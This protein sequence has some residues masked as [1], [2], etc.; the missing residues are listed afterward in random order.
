MWTDA[1]E[2]DLVTNNPWHGQKTK[3]H[4]AKPKGIMTPAE[5]QKIL[6][7]L[8][9][10]FRLFIETLANTGLRWSEALRLV[11]DDVIGQTVHVRKSK[12]RRPRQVKISANLAD[13]LRASLP[14]RGK[15]GGKIDNG[16]FWSGV[17]Y[18]LCK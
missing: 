7:D 17:S 14:F 13:Q 16:T 18:R 11:P 9:P 4:E 5:Y 1:L 12:S 15:H 2:E 8:D 3:Q 6:L 10:H